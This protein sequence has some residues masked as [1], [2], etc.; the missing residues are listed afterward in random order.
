M[1]MYI[2]VSSTIVANVVISCCAFYLFVSRCKYLPPMP[3]G[4]AC[5]LPMSSVSSWVAPV[6]VP[7]TPDPQLEKGQLP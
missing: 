7:G 3:N 4:V 6:Q 2:S 1:T 5:L